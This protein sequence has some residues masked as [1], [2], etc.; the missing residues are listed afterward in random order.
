[1]TDQNQTSDSINPT[2]L[3]VSR[4]RTV[5]LGDFNSISVEVAIEE[6][7][8]PGKK[9]SEHLELMWNQASQYIAKKLLEEGHVE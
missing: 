2:R 3:T 9:K 8:P 6:D 4:R 7:L 5:N 1:M